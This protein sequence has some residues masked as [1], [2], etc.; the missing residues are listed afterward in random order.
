ML[1]GFLALVLIGS[2]SVMQKQKLCERNRGIL[3]AVFLKMNGQVGQL[4]P[5][6]KVHQTSC[7]KK[8]REHKGH[9]TH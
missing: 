9:R 5:L 7:Q 3:Y 1:N 2:G 4:A 6:A 8:E